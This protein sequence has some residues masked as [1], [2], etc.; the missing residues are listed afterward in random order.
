MILA[1]YISEGDTVIDATAGNGYDTLFLSRAVGPSGKV[2]AFD[3]QEQALDA[4]ERLLRCNGFSC[5]RTRR[6]Q[7]PVHAE[8]DGNE[9][10]SS[11]KNSVQ[12]FCPAIFL[13][14]D[15]HEYI[16]G[17]TD[18]APQ[19]IVFNLGYLPGGDHSMVTAPDSTIRSVRASLDILRRGGVISIVTYPGHK[20]GAVEDRLLSEL[21]GSLEPSS[22]EVLFISQHNRTNSPNLF[23]CCKK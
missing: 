22:Y 11:G 4:T 21:F 13:I 8:Q 2:L 19:V 5:K 16:Q 9:A 12:R 7:Y 20:E 14:N 17:Y 15:S 6:H 10:S 3:V 23:V 1:E 18:T